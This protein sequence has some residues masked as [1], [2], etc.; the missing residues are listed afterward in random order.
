MD[1]VLQGKAAGITARAIFIGPAGA[2]P[3]SGTG[4]AGT[5]R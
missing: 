2:T 1:L 3:S 5:V 4:L